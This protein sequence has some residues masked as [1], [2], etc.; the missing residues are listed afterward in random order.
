MTFT[1]TRPD[2]STF[3][4]NLQVNGNSR[5]TLELGSLSAF[6]SGTPFAVSYT[7]NLPVAVNQT[8]DTL[9][10]QAGSVLAGQASTAWIFSE[11]FRPLTGR[12]IIDELRLFNP[13]AEDVTVS[14]TLAFN[15]SESETFLRTVKSRTLGVFNLH[16]F[17]TGTRR[18]AGTVPGVGSFF[19]TYVQAATPITAYALHYDRFLGGGF[20]TVGTA[21]GSTGNPA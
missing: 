9:T 5:A 16:D 21:L 17:V 18:S 14:I 8:T 2:G 12:S 10:E 7:S 4:R 1:F 19:G 6:P 13:A 11:G 15:N 3:K 20:G